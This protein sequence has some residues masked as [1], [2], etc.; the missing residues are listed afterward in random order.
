MFANRSII[1]SV[2]VNMLKLIYTFF[3]G[4]ILSLF[5]G[6]GISTFYKEPAYPEAPTSIKYGYS[7]ERTQAQISEEENYNQSVERFNSEQIKPYN[8]NVSIIVTLFAIAFLAVGVIYSHKINVIADGTL[9][10]GIFTLL[11]G[12]G[13][14]FASGDDAYRFIVIAVGLF[15]AMALGYWKFAKP[16]NEERAKLKAQ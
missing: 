15:V 6:V 4:I 14:G 11:Y 1:I 5:V 16:A 10:G 2:E 8:R 9:L 3:L 12:M 7:G 13:R